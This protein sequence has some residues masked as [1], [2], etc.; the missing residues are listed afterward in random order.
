MF[1]L[2]FRTIQMPMYDGRTDGSQNPLTGKALNFLMPILK[3]TYQEFGLSAIQ[4]PT[5]P[6]NLE[7]GTRYLLRDQS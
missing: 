4:T 1:L 6:Q 2:D 7:L 3:R 5:L